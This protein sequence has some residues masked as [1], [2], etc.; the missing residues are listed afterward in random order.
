MKYGNKNY[1]APQYVHGHRD[2]IYMLDYSLFH[3]QN[4]V[5]FVY[6]VFR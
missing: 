5:E 1:L 2:E 4:I 3:E 6:S